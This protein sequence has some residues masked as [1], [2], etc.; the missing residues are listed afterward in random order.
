[1]KRDPERVKRD[2]EDDYVSV[3]RAQRDYGVVA[4]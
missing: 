2:V 4:S 3:A 1:L